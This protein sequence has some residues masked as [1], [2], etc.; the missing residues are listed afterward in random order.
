LLASVSII[1]EAAL[2]NQEITLPINPGIHAAAL[3]A[4]VLR[5]EATFLRAALTLSINPLPGESLVEGVGVGVMT[6]VILVTAN[7]IY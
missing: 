6:L 1:C 2:N 7:T 5:Y 3:P 4:K